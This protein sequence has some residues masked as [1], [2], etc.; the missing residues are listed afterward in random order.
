M[1][2]QREA[3]TIDTDRGRL[4]L[5]SI[6]GWLRRSYWAGTRPRADVLRSWANSEPVF[7]VYAGDALIGCARVVTDFVAVAYLADVFLVPE[8]R[9]HGLGRWLVETIVAHPDLGTVK[10]L[11]HTRDA[12]GLYRRVGFADAGRRV[13]ERPPPTADR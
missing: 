7:G 8:R 1:Q 13:M 6:L 5:D 3:F 11:L 2:W 12:H 4:D 9:G 10:W